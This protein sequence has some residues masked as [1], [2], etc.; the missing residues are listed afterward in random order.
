MRNNFWKESK[1]RYIYISAESHRIE[2]II[3]GKG[4]FRRDKFDEI[5]HF[6]FKGKSREEEDR[7]A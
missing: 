4:I 1:S 5:L 7:N 2:I 3:L 6:N